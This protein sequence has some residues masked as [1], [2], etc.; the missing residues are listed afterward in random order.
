VS[1]PLGANS[2]AE[3]ALRGR[4]LAGLNVIVTGATSGLG[5]ETT[6][7]LTN[8][9]AHVTMAVRKPDLGREIAERLG[10]SLPK[11][12]GGIEVL[13]LDLSDLDSVRAFA[14]AFL[15]S[16]RPLDLL[17]NNAGIMAV[18]EG[19]TKQ[20]FELQVGTNHLGHFALTNALLPALKA[21]PSARV[22]S[23]SSAAHRQAKP[24]RLVASLSGKPVRYSAFGMYGDSKLANILFVKALAR[25]LPRTVEAYALHPG[26][27]ATKLF[28]T[29]GLAG[30]A[31]KIVSKTFGFLFMKTV[32]QGAATSVYAA[33]APE[34]S[35]HSGAYLSNCAVA[36]PKAFALDE[37]LAEEVWALSERCVA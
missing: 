17:I 26:V 25:R 30:T 18:P 19:K 1:K 20:G 12:S 9:G 14:A 16:G 33:T 21:A 34:L 28:Q 5:A 8:A 2:T 29:K 35:G 15:A 10:R 13:P 32:P 7:V 3:E 36:T 31:F 4:D 22:V 6:R 37:A 27:I 23:L 11:N 24:E